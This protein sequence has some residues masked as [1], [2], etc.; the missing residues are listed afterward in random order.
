MKYPA[1]TKRCNETDIIKDSDGKVIGTILD[2]WRWAHSDLMDNAERGVFAEYLVACAI[3][4]KEQDR[5]NWNSYDLSSKENIT[6]EVKTSAYLQTWGQDKVSNIQFNIPGTLGYDRENNTYEHEKK[7]QA[8]IYVF[9]VHN[10]V[11]QS[12]VDPLDMSQWDFYVIATK[13]INE[14]AKY[15]KAKTISLKPLVKLGAVKCNYGNLYSTVV[16]AFLI[17]NM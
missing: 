12:L 11:Q 14:S 17:N 7:R 9:C 13:A 4:E 5:I 15:A 8:Q 10:A 3:G 6:I 1:F 2:Y 16:N